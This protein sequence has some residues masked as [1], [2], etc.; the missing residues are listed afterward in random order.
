MFWRGLEQ[1]FEAAAEVRG[2]ADVRLVFFFGAVESEDG[3]GVRQLGERGFGIGGIEG[4]GLQFDVHGPLR[5]GSGD[6]H[7]VDAKGG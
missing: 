3:G 4:N 7:A 2:A 6:G 1:A 5:S